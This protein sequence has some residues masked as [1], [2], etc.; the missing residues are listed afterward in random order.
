MQPEKPGVIQVGPVKDEQIAGLDAQVLDGLLVRGLAL[1][2]DDALGQ[3]PGEHRVELDR[4][5][6]AAEFGPGEDRGAEVNGGGVA[7]LDPRGL[8][9]LG[10]HFLGQPLV[11]LIIG[12]L[13]DDRRTR[14]IGV[15]QGGAFHQGQSQMVELA[16][17]PVQAE[18]QVPQTL[19][20]AP[21]AEEHGGQMGPIGEFSGFGSLPTQAVH[22][23]VKNRSRDEL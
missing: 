16:G 17:V 9:G 23:M 3:L 12:F 8:P 18:D 4:P 22:Q 10:L 20:G 15:G 13:K 5:L 11:E 19:P 21:L 2:D 7:D 1:G 6:A 14:F